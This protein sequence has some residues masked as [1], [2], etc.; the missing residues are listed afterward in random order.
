MADILAN[1]ASW[2]HGRRHATMSSDVVY[3]RAAGGSALPIK[4]TRGREIGDQLVDNE[5]T[6]N[7]NQTDW[8][9]RKVDFVV[10]GQFVQPVRLDTVTVGGQVWEVAEIAGEPCWRYSD[11]FENA[12]R[13]HTVRV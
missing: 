12:I 13:I 7:A 9:C 1:A 5:L 8:I 4:A 10:S 3:Q 11:E 2:L 6:S